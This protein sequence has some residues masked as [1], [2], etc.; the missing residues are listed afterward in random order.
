MR[1]RTTFYIVVT[2]CFL[3]L[4][5]AC[6][7][8]NPGVNDSDTVITGYRI[9]GKLIDDFQRPLTGVEVFLYYGIAFVSGDSIS[10]A[11]IPTVQSEVVTVDV[12][13]T[14]GQVVRLLFSGPAPQDLA[15]YFFWDGRNDSGD[16]VRSGI[17][18]ISYTVASVV[19]KSYRMI[20]DGNLNGVT[21]TG[22]RFVIP[23]T[24]LPVDDIA[25]YYDSSD[26]F[27]G[28]YQITSDVFLRFITPTFDRAF[29][30][31]LI[32]NKITDGS[33]TLN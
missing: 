31:P 20:V 11:Y 23:G 30:V 28:Q 10:R 1:K 18:K 9:E 29:K 22:G 7:R 3:F 8:G 19:K 25:P 15:V 5:G 12:K 4:A 27:V 2:G 26:S 13:D 14:T 21:D 6:E 33:R 16:A 24:D 32:K 17:Y